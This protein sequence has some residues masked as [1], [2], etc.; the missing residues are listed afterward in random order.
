MKL[1]LVKYAWR[2]VK[3]GREGERVSLAQNEL[4]KYCI[5]VKKENQVY[6]LRLK[7]LVAAN[8][9]HINNSSSQVRQ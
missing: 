3:G 1:H 9:Q 7:H 6:F 8:N 4:S 2:G 5:L